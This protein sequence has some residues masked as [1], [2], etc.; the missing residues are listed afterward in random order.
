MQDRHVQ[1]PNLPLVDIGALGQLRRIGQPGSLELGGEVREGGSGCDHL[2]IRA[3]A[4]TGQ[5]PPQLRDDR[6]G[7]QDPILA[8]GR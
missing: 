4:H 7:R 1:E 2:V 6:Q 8:G 5:D 3:R